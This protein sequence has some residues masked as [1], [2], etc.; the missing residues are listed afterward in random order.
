MQHNHETFNRHRRQLQIHVRKFEKRAHLVLSKT[1]NVHL[2][3][4]L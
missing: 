4:K 2:T 1:R 3:K